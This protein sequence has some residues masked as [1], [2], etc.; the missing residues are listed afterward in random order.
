[1]VAIAILRDLQNAKMIARRSS[2][3]CRKRSDENK[4]S[5]SLCSPHLMALTPATAFEGR[6]ARGNLGWWWLRVRGRH[7]P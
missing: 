1:K 7:G 6:T 2:R 3:D 4:F 5:A